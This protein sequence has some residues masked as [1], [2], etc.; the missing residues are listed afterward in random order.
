MTV[1]ELI[2]ATIEAKRKCRIAIGYCK[3]DFDRNRFRSGIR[4][5]SRALRALKKEN[6]KHS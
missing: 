3:N 6:G 1:D 2:C 4:E 5:L